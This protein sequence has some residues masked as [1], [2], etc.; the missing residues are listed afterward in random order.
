MKEPYENDSQV[1]WWDKLHQSAFPAFQPSLHP[2][3]LRF[4]HADRGHFGA[5]F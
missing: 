1:Y 5:A 3:Q 4:V 2:S